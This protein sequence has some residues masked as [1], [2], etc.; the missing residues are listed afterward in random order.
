MPLQAGDRLGPYEVVSLLGAGGM[1]EVYRAYDPRLQRQVAV[2]V[3]SPDMANDPTVRSRFEVEAKAASVVN[4]PN[5][6]AVYDFGS[7]NGLLY[8]VWELVDGENLRTAR[9]TTRKALDVAAQIAE[10]LAAAHSA[11][12]VHR[13][14]KPENVMVTADGR[15]KILDFGLAKRTTGLGA[16]D[17]TVDMSSGRTQPGILMGTIGYMS[18][19]QVRAQEV[20]H[21]SDIFSFGVVLYEILAGQRAFPGDSAV[22]VLNAI[23]TLEPR[24][25]PESVPLAARQVVA[26]CLEKS[27]D[28]RFQSARDLAFALRSLSGGAVGTSVMRAVLDVPQRPWYQRWEI[29]SLVAAALL[30][31]GLFFVGR[32]TGRQPITRFHQL[33]FQRGFVSGAR[34]SS[35]GRTVAYSAA[36]GG[37]PVEVYTSRVES[38]ES[39]PLGIK[40]AHVFAVSNSGEIAVGLDVQYSMNHQVATLARVPLVGGTPRVLVTQVSEA[41]WDPKG[42]QLL[43]VRDSGN[44]RKLE[45]PPGKVLFETPGGI[46]SPRF[47][48]DGQRIAFLEHPRQSDDRGFVSVLELGQ[49]RKQLVEREALEGLVWHRNGKEIWFGSASAGE[50]NTIEAVTLSGDTRVVRDTPGGLKLHDLSGEG[51]LLFTRSDSFQEMIG[52]T[53]D[54][55]QRNLAWLN[56]STPRDLS[57]DGS[58]LLFTEA[59]QG[60]GGT[61]KVCVRPTSGAP[62]VVLGDGEAFALS[63]DGQRALAV[64]YSNPPKFVVLPTGPGSPQQIPNAGAEFPMHALFHP[65]G[66]RVVFEGGVAGH[67]DQLWVQ[68][69]GSSQARAF[70]PE[71]VRMTGKAVSPD[72]SLA[73]ATGP[74]GKLALY[75]VDGGAPRPLAGVE[76]NERFIRWAPDGRSVFIYS[77]STIPTQINRVEITTGLRT[78]GREFAPIDRTGVVT[79]DHLVMT[80]DTTT[81]VYGFQ[82]LLTNLIMAHGLE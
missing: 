67:A 17:A 11:G 53:P 22:Q 35:D 70:T 44:V 74:D 60:A 46:R 55:A 73:V 36:W 18:P 68:P 7:H 1:G 9:L 72:G 59:G 41:D 50:A 77:P 12:I 33:S 66:T 31:V 37:Q 28:Q 80:P 76:P 6:V 10:G 54:N 21:R 14:L 65:D 39:R 29:L 45:Y 26:H 61:Y 64:V 40:N 19:E 24:E 57:T 23:L 82:R 3:L 75:P 4:H 32:F 51:H 20:D 63:P 34:F 43:I 48:P 79:I 69:L 81:T 49:P 38:P 56:A 25:L 42:E 71:G 5:I 30:G 16:S 58:T 62:H 13:D 27:P 8:I 15:A 78:H 52:V 47:S 2:K